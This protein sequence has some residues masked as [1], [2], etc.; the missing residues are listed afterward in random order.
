MAQ[1]ERCFVV[2]WKLKCNRFGTSIGGGWRGRGCW[3]LGEEPGLR[4]WKYRREGFV[5][6]CGW[7]YQEFWLSGPKAMVGIFVVLPPKE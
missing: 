5:L 4:G 2:A 6:Q 3:L 1:P 7:G